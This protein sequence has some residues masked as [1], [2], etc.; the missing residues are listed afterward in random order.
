VR[1]AGPD[2]GLTHSRPLRIKTGDG[3]IWEQQPYTQ[4]GRRTAKGSKEGVYCVGL[5]VT[6]VVGHQ[7]GTSVMSGDPEAIDHR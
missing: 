1:D 4:L 5:T 7:R 6:W 3:K 2:N